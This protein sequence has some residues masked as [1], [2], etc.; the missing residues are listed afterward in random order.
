VGE[1][2]NVQEMLVG[3]PQET[4]SFWNL[5]TDRKRILMNPEDTEHKGMMNWLHLANG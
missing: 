1:I 5:G 3:K 4:A 2:R